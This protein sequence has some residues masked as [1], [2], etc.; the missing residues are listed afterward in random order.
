MASVDSTGSSVYGRLRSGDLLHA[1]LAVALLLGELYFS[2]YLYLPCF[3]P[4]H[5][6]SPISLCKALS[7]QLVFRVIPLTL[8][9]VPMPS[10]PSSL[11]SFNASLGG[12]FTAVTVNPYLLFITPYQHLL[13]SCSIVSPLSFLKV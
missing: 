13:C 5:L 7:W 1:G 2:L 3:S 8:K 6:I 10:T 11:V 4:L 12:W 9:L